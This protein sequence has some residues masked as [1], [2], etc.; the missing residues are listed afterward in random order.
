MSGWYLESDNITAGMWGNVTIS[1]ETQDRD[2]LKW[3]EM[4]HVSQGKHGKSMIFEVR[5]F[6][7]SFQKHSE[8]NLV[9]HV[10]QW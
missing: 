3:I 10:K 9:F 5:F 7:P 2:R 8:K 1:G 4:D 6:P